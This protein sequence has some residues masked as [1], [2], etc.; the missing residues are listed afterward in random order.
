M[1]VRKH[2]SMIHHVYIVIFLPEEKASFLLSVIIY[3]L[4]NHNCLNYFTLILYLTSLVLTA[5]SFIPGLSI[6]LAGFFF[7]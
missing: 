7:L 6:L 5:S 2:F 1:F 3:I 4:D